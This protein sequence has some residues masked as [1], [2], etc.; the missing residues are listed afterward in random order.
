[1]SLP[2]FPAALGVPMTTPSPGRSEGLAADVAGAPADGAMDG[3]AA[4][5]DEA[6]ASLDALTA[7]ALDGGMPAL[8]A[9]PAPPMPA[10]AAAAAPVLPAAAAALPA[11]A[12]TAH[13]RT[14]LAPGWPP[15]GLSSL[16]PGV[17]VLDAR[18]PAPPA[19]PVLVAV[20]GI[21][22]LAPLPEAAERGVMEATAP[23]PLPQGSAGRGAL[24]P[25]AG[26][27]AAMPTLQAIASEA[28]AA[29]MARAPGELRV[30][31]VDDG[32]PA[33]LTAVTETR[34]AEPLP[35]LGLGAL[36]APA[37]VVHKLDLA[38]AFPAPVPL[39]SPRF[40]EE[41]GARL[42]WIA[43]QQGGEATLRIS[44][45]GLGPVEIRLKLDGDRVEL[46]FAAT[47]QETRQALQDALPKLREMLAQQ[48]LHLGHADVGHRQASSSNDGRREGAT[49]VIDDEANDV[50]LPR[51]E[52][53]ESTPV[54]GR[55]GR[56]LL[57]LY[58]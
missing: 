10:L 28:V 14:A 31:V 5:L 7:G 4:V 25:P 21:A 43:E 58:A 51:S 23:S 55:G 6:A 8:P 45:D 11:S 16:F 38:H 34:G 40:A 2:S 13:D 53:R 37:S 44:P 26:T 20:R 17:P 30:P 24:A 52:R 9:V 12:D 49:G 3:F 1:M 50:T 33:A 57:D 54:I 18:V 27:P 29:A 35:E 46:G 48:G 42:Q 41:V 47:Q 22:S 19:E 56:G 36:A 39:L 15:P 32:D